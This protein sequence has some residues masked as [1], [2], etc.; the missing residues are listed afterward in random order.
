MIFRSVVV[1]M[2]VLFNSHLQANE[3][4]DNFEKRVDNIFQDKFPADSPGC[5]VGVFK[6][7]SILFEKSYGLAN[8]EHNV[9]LSAKS[10][11]RLASVSKQFTAFSVLLL[12]DEGKIDLEDDIRIYLPDLHDYGTKVSINSMLGHFSGMADYRDFEKLLPKPLLSSAG[13]PFRLGNQDYLTNNE[14]YDVIK[15]LPLFMRRRML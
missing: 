6:D 5:S 9:P 8:L 13:G 4:N 11:H 15:T 7:Q 10:V 14:Y 2:F 3:V 12:A 1:T